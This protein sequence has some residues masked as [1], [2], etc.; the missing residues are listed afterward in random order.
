MSYPTKHGL[1]VHQGRWCKKVKNAKKPSRKET[2]ADRIVQKRKKEEQQK[3]Y[4]KVKIGNE[5]VD[6]VLEFEYFGA[7]VPN[8]GD[9]E[10]PITHRS[11]SPGDGL[12]NIQRLSW[13]VRCQ[14]LLVLNCTAH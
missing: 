6:N 8:D 14:L 13:P 4:P 11:T 2:V 5:E 7:N 10:V 9:P 3:S 12:V 1:A